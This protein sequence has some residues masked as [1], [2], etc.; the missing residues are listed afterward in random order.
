MGFGKQNE[1]GFEARE[2]GLPSGLHG[3][4]KMDGLNAKHGKRAAAGKETRCARAS[5]AIEVLPQCLAEPAIFGSRNFLDTDKITIEDVFPFS[6]KNVG[7]AAGHP[8]A[9]VETERPENQNDAAGHIFATVLADT[10]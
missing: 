10:L 5:G 3:A 9:E 8:G 4:L 6:A 2:D 7:E 1:T